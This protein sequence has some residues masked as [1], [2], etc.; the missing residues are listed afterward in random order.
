MNAYLTMHG[1]GLQACLKVDER[2]SSQ[3]PGPPQTRTPPEGSV[4]CSGGMEILRCP[5]SGGFSRRLVLCIGAS[6]GRGSFGQGGKISPSPGLAVC[7]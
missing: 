2:L 7:P 1:H 4:S 3:T 5:A 6:K